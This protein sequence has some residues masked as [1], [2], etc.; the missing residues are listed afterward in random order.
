MRIHD[1]ELAGELKSL[2]NEGRFSSQGDIIEALK[3]RGFQD[4]NQSKISRTLN[5]LGAIRTRNANKELKYCLPAEI[6]IP[7]LDASLSTLIT[8]IDYNAHMVVIKTTPAAAQIVARLIDSLGRS[9]GILGC[10]GG[11][12]TIFVTPTQ[13]SSVE[14][15]YEKI[16]QLVSD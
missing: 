5:Y 1:K 11:D 15:L 6:Q 10:I 2:I 3:E 14:K 9:V 7:S 13:D 12:D 16:S 4:I 8:E